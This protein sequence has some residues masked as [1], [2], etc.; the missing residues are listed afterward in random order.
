MKINLKTDNTLKNLTIL[1]RAERV[2]AYMMTEKIRLNRTIAISR[3]FH[4]PSRY[5]SIPTE[6][7]LI[8]T[9]TINRQEIILLMIRRL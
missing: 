5:S 1:K 4:S 6:R 2:C 3:R 8:I 7:I 9:S